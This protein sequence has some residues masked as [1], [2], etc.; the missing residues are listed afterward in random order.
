MVKPSNLEQ[1]FTSWNEGETGYFKVGPITLKVTSDATELEKIAKETAKE[2]EAAVSY[3]W[4][5]GQK[6]S[7]AWWLEWGGFAL[8]EEIPYYAATSFPE[9]EEKLKDFDPKNNDF[10]CDTVEEFKEMLFSAYDEDLRAEDLKRGFKLWLKSLDKPILEA[11]EKD[12]LSW[13]SRAR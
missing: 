2:I 12:L 13:T 6:N 10:E 3:A 4:D 11:L 7:S 9:A 5:L 1:Y 8:E